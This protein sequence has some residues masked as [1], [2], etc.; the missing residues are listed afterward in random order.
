MHEYGSGDPL[1][2]DTTGCELN[3]NGRNTMKRVLV[4]AFALAILPVLLCSSVE[5]VTIGFSPGSQEVL[6]GSSFGVDLVVSDLLG[7]LVGTFDLTI[8]FDPGILG[9]VGYSLGT[10]LGDVASIDPETG[11]P[12]EAIDL[13][14]GQVSPGQI[15][16]AELSFLSA[17]D[18]SGQPSSGFTLATLTFSALSIGE[19]TGLSLSSVIIGDAGGDPFGNVQMNNG[20]VTV[21]APVPEP[22]TLLLLASGLA[23]L[24]GFRRKIVASPR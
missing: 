5:A 14:P 12:L 8:G 20:S 9:F 13:S 17:S 4:V 1:Y 10:Y 6:E 19:K 23:G 7:A 22:S 16:L 21:G 2:C 18:L 24:V 3:E 15:N 11:F